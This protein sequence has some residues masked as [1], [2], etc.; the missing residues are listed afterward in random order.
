MRLD[1][2]FEGQRTIV[3]KAL[4]NLDELIGFIAV[5]PMPRPF[6]FNT[7]D[8]WIPS[9]YLLV[10]VSREIRRVLTANQQSWRRKRLYVVPAIFGAAALDGFSN[11]G[12]V[13]SP[14][15]F[16]FLVLGD[17]G[18]KVGRQTFDFSVLCKTYFKLRV[19]PLFGG[20]SIGEWNRDRIEQSS[21]EAGPRR[22]H[23]GPDVFDHESIDTLRSTSRETESHTTTHGMANQVESIPPELI[24]NL[25]EISGIVF[26]SVSQ[27]RLKRPTVPALVVNE[28]LVLTFEG[29]RNSPPV[30]RE[31]HHSVEKNELRSARI[32]SRASDLIMEVG[33]VR[34]L[35]LQPLATVR[36]FVW[37]PPANRGYTA[38][39]MEV[40]RKPHLHRDWIDPHAYGI[41]KALQKGG[42]VTYL[43]GGCV[44][45]LLL[46]NHPKDFDIATDAPPPQVKR[47]IYQSF[48]I[49]KR[50]RLVLV[51]REDQQY[52]VATFRRETKPEDFPE[53]ETPFG[54]NL[55]GTPEE[56]AR[57]RD[58]TI[59][60]LFYDPINDQLI[61][62]VN[63]LPDIDARLLRMIGTPVP[64]LIED[65]IRILRGL[66]LS[67]KLGLIIEAELRAAMQS[68]ASELARSVLP[69]RREEIL[70]I[71][72]LDDPLMALME[73]FD[74]DILK[75]VIPTLDDL[76]RSP[77]RRDLFVE[78]FLT[79]STIV[80]DPTD[81]TQLFA[82]L[83]YSMLQAAQ[84]GP[85]DREE[86]VTL[87]DP[88]F[89]R[90]MMDELG[91]YKL[92]QT[93]LVQAV[94]L[95]S[96]LARTE[97]FKRRGERRQLGLIKNEGFKLS[98]RIAWADYLLS[99]SQAAFW[100]EAMERLGPELRKIET[101]VKAKKRRRPRRR[102]EGGPVEGGSSRKDG[103]SMKSERLS[104]SPDRPQGE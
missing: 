16:L 42:F 31:P 41:V 18:V 23:A 70:K 17:V 24:G 86:P 53:G 79:L 75:Y 101:E 77:E 67:H 38:S 76:L 58:F 82:W 51:K 59:N 43:V 85:S 55:F 49:G 71:L 9:Q 69:R 80:D 89:Q 54:D 44:R 28:H 52:E 2:V 30:G 33:Q 95:L 99:P 47:L 92:E 3:Q 36:L 93:V 25:L 81:P 32:V 13:E 37:S 29:F 27:S 45:D 19:E 26:R 10:E 40:T 62:F 96:S 102:R 78:H 61:D 104:A 63:G 97:D 60:G 83:V 20:S 8:A 64:R 98:L 65:P 84:L 14:H 22:M 74:L 4:E 87:E 57:R 5:D 56:D 21:D 91:M 46:G 35:A 94:E 1:A 72:R 15:R 100:Y 11:P 103:D 6:D 88:I 7:F 68:Q 48:I 12:L 73:A 34:H 39:V 50:F 66:R 90:L